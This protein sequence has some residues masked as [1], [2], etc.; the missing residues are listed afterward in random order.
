MASNSGPA[1]RD[2]GHITHNDASSLLAPGTRCT[3]I[4]GCP[5]NI[6]MIVEAVHRI[7]GVPP[8][9][10]GYKIR[11]V[12]GRKFAQL[13]NGNELRRGT[14]D[15]AHTERWKLRPLVAPGLEVFVE[16]ERKVVDHAP[17]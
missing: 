10:D 5:E 8:Y 13:W 15:V 1:A 6:G 9:T 17:A 12:T 11:T 14:M 7:G 4:A 2:N 3:I 16:T